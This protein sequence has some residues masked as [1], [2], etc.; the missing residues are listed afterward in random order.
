L[1]KLANIEKIFLSKNTNVTAVSNVDITIN[2]GEI[3][4]VIGFSGAGKSTLLRMINL[5]EKP[6]KGT[7]TIGEKIISTL[8]GRQLRQERQKIGM[9]FQHFN[10][11]WSR[12]VEGNISLPLE[13]A[14]VP[15][16][17][18][19]AQ[20]K[21]LVKVVGLEG[22]E[23]SYPA[24]LSGGQKQRVGIAR[25]LAN[26]PNILLCDEATSA[27]DPKTTKSILE[28]LTT[29]NKEL[30]ITI[31]LITH[32]FEVIKQICHRVA[33]MENGSIIEQGSVEQIFFHPEQE[34]TKQFVRNDDS[35]VG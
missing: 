24:Q 12:T 27:L 31:V 23:K 4:G 15:K 5:L 21:K 7:V 6:T 19:E 11:L 9:I 20:V 29:I 17:E 13:L 10:L 3:F 32:E 28:L 25:A 35:K 18:R 16:E 22:K 26:N 2:N 34:A 30:G 33:V 8:R 1:I 14:N